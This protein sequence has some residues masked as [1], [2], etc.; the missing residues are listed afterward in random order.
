VL[1][2]VG[3]PVLWTIFTI[4]VGGML[5]LDL[6]VFNRKPHEVSFR[7]ALRWSLI[8]ISIALL[9]NAGIYF[10]FGRPLALEFL[11]G[12]LVEK[13]LSVDNIFVF[14]ALFRAFRV[15]PMFQ[16]RVLFWG[17]IGAIVLRAIFIALGAALLERFHWV[18]YFF[19]A[20]LVAA[21]IRFLVRRGEEVHPER[22]PL[23]RFLS[24]MVRSVPEYEGKQ[25]FVMREGRRYATALFVVLLAIEATDVVFAVDSIPAIFAIT[26]DPFIVYTSNIFAI[27]GLR[28]L[29]FLL[30]AVMDRFIYLKTG[31]AAVLIFVGAKMLLVDVVKIPIVVSLLVIATILAVSLAASF[32]ASRR[33]PTGNTR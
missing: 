19:G 1:E 23:F 25:F 32:I 29:Y 5:A 24:K 28:A 6:G 21:G 15:P 2:S 14:V 12:Y 30:A 27:L 22:N 31:L 16:H 8:W 33:Q 3:T 9:F 18:I 7:E 17:V 10:K 13:A 26:D 4:M 11:T 20:L